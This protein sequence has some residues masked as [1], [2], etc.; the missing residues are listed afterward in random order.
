MGEVKSGHIYVIYLCNT[1]IIYL[2]PPTVYEVPRSGIISKPQ[3]QH[4]LQLWQRWI[5]NPLCQA[6]DQT[7]VLALQ[8]HSRSLHATAGTLGFIFFIVY[9]KQWTRTFTDYPL[10]SAL[11][12]FL[13]VNLNGCLNKFTSYTEFYRGSS[14]IWR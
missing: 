1:Y 8:I 13:R 2:P 5:L 14:I 10:C 11:S 12:F 7:C 9:S 3:L 4:K 6:R